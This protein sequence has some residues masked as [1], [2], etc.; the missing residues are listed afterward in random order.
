MYK[1]QLKSLAHRATHPNF[2]PNSH[3]KKIIKAQKDFENAHV[4]AD[5]T[6]AEYMANR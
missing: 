1:D 6:I 4:T 2:D 3:A 5:Q